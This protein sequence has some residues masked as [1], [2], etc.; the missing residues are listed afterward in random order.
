MNDS[1]VC[2]SD[3]DSSQYKKDRYINTFDLCFS[4]GKLLK[5]KFPTL[6]GI[7]Y[8]SIIVDSIGFNLVNA[9]I[10]KPSSD[11]QKLNINLQPFK[12]KIQILLRRIIESAST[13]D[14]FLKVITTL[15]GN[16]AKTLPVLH[17]ENQIISIIASIFFARFAIVSKDDNDKIAS[18]SLSNNEN[19]TWLSK[20]PKFE[21]NIPI[22]Y[23]EDSLSYS[24]SG[25]GDKKLYNVICD[26]GYYLRDFSKDDFDNV[27]NTWFNNVCHQRNE[28][29]SVKS[30]TST[31][32]I[33]LNIYT[34]QT[35]SAV[36]AY[37]NKPWDIEHI[38][39]KK[40]MKE[41]LSRINASL[42]NEEDQLKLPISSIGN[43]CYL[44][45]SLNRSKEEKTIYQAG[46][47]S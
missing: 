13:V 16:S 8:D 9:C 42:A 2:V 39:P 34:A 25:T 45:S 37:N 29:K 35:V 33:L 6:F 18:V 23:V 12:D 3:F 1:D 7:D 22:V 40:Q 19:D 47:N 15:K 30:P 17:S 4:F 5:K 36:D 43:I 14:G 28:E 27:Y 11:L 46:L 44:P 32:K 26:L 31:D 10:G 20:K 38:C 21:K 24:W 41:A